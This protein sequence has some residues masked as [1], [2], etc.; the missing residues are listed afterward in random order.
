MARAE[1]VRGILVS[2]GMKALSSF[3]TDS[4]SEQLSSAMAMF[5]WRA[6]CSHEGRS[7]LIAAGAA[8]PTLPDTDYVDRRAPAADENDQV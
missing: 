2:G 5:C 8:L 3:I 6:S 1:T 7:G 4:P